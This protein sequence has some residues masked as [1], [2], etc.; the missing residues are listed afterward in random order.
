MQF[1]GFVYTYIDQLLN[2]AARM[3][4]R[5]CGRFTCPIVLG[6]LAGGGIHAVEHH[7]ESTEAM[8]AHTPGLKVVIPSSPRRAYGQPEARR[9]VQALACLPAGNRGRNG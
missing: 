7:P 4:M 1:T 6:S 8:F 2:H 3:Q 5:T 9:G